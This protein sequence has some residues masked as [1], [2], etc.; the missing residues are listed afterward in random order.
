MA[1]TVAVRKDTQFTWAGTDKEC[2]KLKGRSLA[3]SEQ[4]LRADLRRQGV[5]PTRISKQSSLFQKGGK[6]TP[7]DIAVFSRQLATMLA[8]GIPLVQS[9]EIIGNG[10]DK[11]AMQKLVL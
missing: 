3:A 7:E 2:N 10:H 11:P 6:V 9:F 8:A 1:Q 4:A 5:V